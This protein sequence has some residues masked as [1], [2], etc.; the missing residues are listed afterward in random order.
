[1][2]QPFAVAVRETLASASPGS[3]GATVALP[4]SVAAP[5]NKLRRLMHVFAFILV[6]S[7]ELV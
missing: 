5:F 1:V 2:A 3:K 7:D 4:K 6:S